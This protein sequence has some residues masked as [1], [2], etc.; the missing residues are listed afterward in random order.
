MQ[1]FKNLST[2]IKTLKV[3]LNN[4]K[5]IYIMYEKPETNKYMV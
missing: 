3:E 4:Y 2:N 1:K 5:E